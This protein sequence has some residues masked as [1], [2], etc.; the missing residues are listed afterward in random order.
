MNE[1]DRAIDHLM[2]RPSPILP[3]RIALAPDAKE[4]PGAL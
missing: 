4:H 1:S 2:Y 3:D